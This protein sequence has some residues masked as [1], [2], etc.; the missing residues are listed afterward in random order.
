MLPGDDRDDVQVTSVFNEQTSVARGVAEIEE[1]VREKIRKYDRVFC[2]A[3]GRS[4]D[5]KRGYTENRKI[6]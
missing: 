1:P 2:T 5:E 6:E 4:V 3:I